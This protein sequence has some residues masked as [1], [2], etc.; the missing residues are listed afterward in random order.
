[1]KH[2]NTEQIAMRLDGLLHKK[3]RPR[4]VRENSY[5]VAF[6]EDYVPMLETGRQQIDQNWAAMKAVG[7]LP[8]GAP[9]A[10][11]GRELDGLELTVWMIRDFEHLLTSHDEPD[12]ALVEFNR[13]RRR[14]LVLPEGW[15]S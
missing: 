10:R 7:W 1:M 12:M 3:I 2:L 8:D 5:A 13:Q 11:F 9:K 4:W 15:V 14:K 6:V